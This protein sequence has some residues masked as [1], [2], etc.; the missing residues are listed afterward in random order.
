MTR[1]PPRLQVIDND[2]S[3]DIVEALERALERAKA[4]DLELCAIVTLQGDDLIASY[5]WKDD[6]ERPW[7]L[8]IA[9][10]EDAKAGLLEDGL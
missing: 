9:A 2:G 1:R 3:V 10:L 4:G 7:C 6:L 8:F 5:T